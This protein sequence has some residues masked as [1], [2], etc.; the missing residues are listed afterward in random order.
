MKLPNARRAVVETEKITNY[1]LSAS[2]RRG[3]SKANFIVRFGFNAD[4]WQAFVNALKL[5]R[6]NGKVVEIIETVYGLSYEVNGTIETPDGRNPRIKTV[7]NIIQEPIT[8]GWS[9]WFR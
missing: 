5:Q 4:N 8:P 7:G 3:R 1:L 6:A 2:G 9:R